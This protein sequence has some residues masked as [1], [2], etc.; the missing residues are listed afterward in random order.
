MTQI[1]MPN[2]KNIKL[3]LVVCKEF[4]EKPLVLYTNISE[5]LETIALR[6]VKAYLMRWRIEEFYAFKKQGLNFED[7]RV[8][9][10]NSIKNLDL[11]LTIAIGFIAALCEKGGETVALLINVSKRISKTWDFMKKTKF[12]FYAVLDGI[13]SV[14]ATLRC[15]ISRFFATPPTDYQ[16]SFAEFENLG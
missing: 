3:N 10:L 15:G 4:G 8:R 11:L 12:F 9:S 6:I 14:L 2:L 13:T 7:F 5:T 1:V 16:L